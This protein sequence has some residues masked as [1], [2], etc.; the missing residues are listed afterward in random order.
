MST[1]KEEKPKVGRPSKYDGEEVVKVTVR[2]R[3]T[4]AEFIEKKLGKAS[5]GIESIVAK[6]VRRNSKN[7]K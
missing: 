7:K 3:A 6:Y 5:I 2:I 4:D 1:K